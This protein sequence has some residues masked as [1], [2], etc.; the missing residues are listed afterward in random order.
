[1]QRVA[2]VELDFGPAGAIAARLVVP[3]FS[4]SVHTPLVAGLRPTPAFAA[5]KD[6]DPRVGGAGIDVCRRDAARRGGEGQLVP[7]NGHD[8]LLISRAGSSACIRASTA[9]R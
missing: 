1:M 6:G 9:T 7:W 8:G 5:G 3:D 2:R 4:E